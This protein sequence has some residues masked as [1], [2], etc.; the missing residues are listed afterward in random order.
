VERFSH[1]SRYYDLFY[2]D[3]DYAAEAAFVGGVLRRFAPSAESVLELGCGT[4]KHARLLAEQ[5]FRVHGIDLSTAMLDSIGVTGSAEGFTYCSGDARTYRDGRRYDAAVSLFHVMSYQTTDADLTAA[6]ATAA[7]HLGPG[8]VFIFDAWHGPAVL[9]Q[10]PEVRDRTVDADD[11][12]VR[13]IATPTMHE[14]ECVVDVAY[15]IEVTR[16]DTGATRAFEELHRM[17]YL[18]TDEVESFLA[19]AGFELKLACEFGTSGDLG[20]D[21]WNACYVGRRT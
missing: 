18:F 19:D 12:V 10:R 9:A 2:A 13:R 15:H 4:G 20:P 8:G 5:G 7:A 21:T 14:D 16:R 1:Y 17:R 6:F 3:K 11:V